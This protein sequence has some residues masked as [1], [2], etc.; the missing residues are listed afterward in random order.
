[1]RVRAHDCTR[2]RAEEHVE[3]C[4]CTV[5]PPSR[6]HVSGPLH[7]STAS[8]LFLL[9]LLFMFVMPSLLMYH[10]IILRMTEAAKRQDC[11]YRMSRKYPDP[12]IRKG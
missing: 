4:W 11:R 10:L 9:L 1:M 5:C 3:V 6:H 2:E 12:S 8:S 7:A